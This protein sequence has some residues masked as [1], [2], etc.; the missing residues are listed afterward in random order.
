MANEPLLVVDD[1]VLSLKIARALLTSAGY[2]VQTASDAETAL[3][4]LETFRPRVI[5]T[6]IFLPGM[7]GL[8]LTRR[9]K[10]DPLRRDIKILALTGSSMDVDGA[11]AIKAGCDGYIQKPVDPETLATIVAS[12]IAAAADIER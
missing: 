4:M 5:L 9:L 12:Y 6:D 2:E 3:H 11:R 7:D 10:S 1:S 8:E